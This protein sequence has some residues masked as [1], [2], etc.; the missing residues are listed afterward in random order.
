MDGDQ[1]C[2]KE[3]THLFRLHTEVSCWGMWCTGTKSC[4]TWGVL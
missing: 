4:V 1:N 2:W 3:D